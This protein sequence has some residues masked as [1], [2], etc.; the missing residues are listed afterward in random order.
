MKATATGRNAEAAVADYLVENGFKILA[1]NWRTRWCEIDIIAQ[2]DKTIHFIE[3]KY[4]FSESHGSGFEY[5]TPHK[6][7]QIKFAGRFWTAQNHWD[8]DY[9]LIAAEVTGPGFEN[10]HLVEID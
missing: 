4:R 5:I 7:N 1:K 10:I 9:R 8:G 2:K 3:V 6:L